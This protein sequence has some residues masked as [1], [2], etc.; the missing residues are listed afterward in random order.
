MREKKTDPRLLSGSSEVPESD[1]VYTLGGQLVHN[2][3]GPQLRGADPRWGS[4]DCVSHRLHGSCVWRGHTHTD[5][6]NGEGYMRASLVLGIMLNSIYFIPACACLPLYPQGSPSLQ[7]SWNS[8]RCLPISIPFSSR[9][10]GLS[11]PGELIAGH[12]IRQ[13]PMGSRWRYCCDLFS[14][15]SYSAETRPA[16][17]FQLRLVCFSTPRWNRKEP[18][19]PEPRWYVSTIYHDSY[20]NS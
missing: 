20:K 8:Q 3:L 11:S 16:L 17:A 14:R 9:K 13:R 12:R 2:P 6:R 4:G 1:F 5:M 19:L 10:G 15:P 7:D 18:N